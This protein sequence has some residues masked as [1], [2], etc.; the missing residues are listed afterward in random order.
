MLEILYFAG[1]IALV[2]L[3]FLFFFHS[4][5]LFF[6]NKSVSKTPSVGV[7]VIVA[8]HNERE[9]LQKLLPLLQKQQ[10]ADYEII[11]VDDR[12]EDGSY[13]FLYEEKQKDARLKIVRIDH[14]PEHISNKKY[15][16]TLGIKAAKYEHLLFTDADCLPNSEHWISEMTGHFDESTHFVLGVS[17]YFKEKG[18]LNWLI[19]YETF[20]TAIQYLSYALARLPYM[21]VGRNLAYTK[22]TFLQGKGFHHHLK[23]V[24]GDD[25]LFVNEHANRKNTKISVSQDA[26]V[27]SYPKKMWRAW[28]RQ[29]NRHLSVGKFYKKTHLFLLGL[30]SLS[31]SLFWFLLPWLLMV[32]IFFWAH[33]QWE[34][35]L[36]LGIVIFRLFFWAS[37]HFFASKKLSFASS[38]FFWF[39]FDCIYVFF[40]VFLGIKAFFSKPEQ[41]I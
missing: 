10:Y 20:H 14:T 1:V 23:I 13:E 34:H 26:Q 33:F 16:I 39:F 37:L 31:H 18:L 11:I 30:Q 17:P 19:R 38:W 8:A 12:S 40:I 3:L 5:L 2:Q 6:K 36:A 4:R 32:A 9:N 29:K 24:G 35:W 22:G 21:G 7:S 41:W 28:F 27:Y 25:D 15:A